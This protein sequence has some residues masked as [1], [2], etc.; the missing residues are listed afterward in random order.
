ML[1]TT[2]SHHHIVSCCTLIN[3]YSKKS[4]GH[5]VYP[6]SDMSAIEQF[7]CCPVCDLG[8]GESYPYRQSS[9]GSSGK[10]QF[11]SSATLFAGE[12]LHGMSATPSAFDQQDSSSGQSVSTYNGR[13]NTYVPGHLMISFHRLLHEEILNMVQEDRKVS[14]QI[15]RRLLLVLL[16]SQFGD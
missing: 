4:C 15:W 1:T 9:S 16:Y 7:K 2:M 8:G 5:E 11:P 6:E 13:L 14:N 3:W 12:P 10:R